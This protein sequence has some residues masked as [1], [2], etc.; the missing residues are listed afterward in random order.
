[1]NPWDIGKRPSTAEIL[2]KHG[3]PVEEYSDLWNAR[4][5]ASTQH[6]RLKY[7]AEWKAWVVYDGARWVRDDSGASA[8]LAAMD[9]IGDLFRVALTIEDARMRGALIDHA[10][11]SETKRGIDAMVALARAML[12]TSVSEFDR[13]RF[14]LNTPSGIVDLRSGELRKHQPAE[15][16]TMI[17]RA[18]FEPVA[19][20][21]RFEAF[22]ARVQPD[23]A[24]QA[25]LQRL[26]G[27]WSTGVIREQILAFLQGGGANGKSTFIGL[28]AR[29]LG[30]YAITGAPDL[31]LAKHGE[32]HPTELADLEGRRL[33]VCHETDKG[34]ALAEGRIKAI[35]G[36]DVISARRMGENFRRFEPTAKLA[37]LSNPKPRIRGTDDGIRRRVK[38]I[39]FGVRIPDGEQNPDLMEELWREEAPG[40][41]AWI[42]RGAVAWNAQTL[43][44][45]SGVGDAS[46]DYFAEQDVLGE[47]I[48]DKCELTAGAWTSTVELFNAYRIWCELRNEN[49]GEQRGFSDDLAER[50]GLERKRTSRGRGFVGITLRRQGSAAVVPLARGA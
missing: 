35:T 18:P 42:V 3:A 8:S 25:F 47:F 39:P 38:L 2:D 33:V 6:R 49:P 20:A 30:D 28:V 29:A 26:A 31:L 13:D 45:P 12:S 15:L 41:L 10:R 34:R 4:V 1:M 16:I 32:S 37:L 27:Y 40:I 7:A 44:Y 21:P 36:G 17:T 23:P 24:M 46:R 11:K 14:A 48:A 43:A 50:Q 9:T 19:K 22:L 5:L